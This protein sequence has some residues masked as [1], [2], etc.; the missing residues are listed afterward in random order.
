MDL[1][2][3]T[4][5]KKEKIFRTR[6]YFHINISYTLVFTLIHCPQSF[7]SNIE[8]QRF[9]VQT[10]LPPL[11]LM[12]DSTD[13]TKQTDLTYCLGFETLFSFMIDSNWQV[14]T[15]SPYILSRIWNPYSFQG[16][17]KLSH[18]EVETFPLDF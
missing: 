12:I 11:L 8:L 16:W 2:S 13:K 4:K 7:N 6:S 1:Q 5:V 3:W 9:L 14:Q 10:S 15:N 18:G 17:I